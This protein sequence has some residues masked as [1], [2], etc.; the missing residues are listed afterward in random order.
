MPDHSVYHAGQGFLELPKTLSVSKTR[1]GLV[2]L[3]L[4]YTK[5][6]F[7]VYLLRYFKPPV[8]LTVTLHKGYGLRLLLGYNRWL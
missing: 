7:Q 3:L 8:K 5:V 4:V 1:L 2:S 6:Y